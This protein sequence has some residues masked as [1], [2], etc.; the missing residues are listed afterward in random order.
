M[1]KE[2]KEFILRGNVLDLAIGVIIG[3]A[4]TTI[5]T[6]LVDNL[7]NPLIGLLVQD[8]SLSQLSIKMAGT[9]FE[10]GSF[11]NDVLNFLITAFVI[12]IMIKVINKLF[13]KKDGEDIIV[14]EEEEDV[15][16]EIRDL[17]KEMRE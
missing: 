1:I 7:I 5:I 3:A 15:L 9:T 13:S 6:S 4:F 16:G 14:L 8:A 2:F 11:L 12:F 17:L 10:Y